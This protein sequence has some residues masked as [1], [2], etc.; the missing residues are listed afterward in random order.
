MPRLHKIVT[1][2]DDAG[3]GAARIVREYK[4]ED[5]REIDITADERQTLYGAANANG[6]A[7]IAASLFAKT[8]AE[9]ERDALQARLDALNER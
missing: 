4:I 5:G 7:E 1:I 6:A 3:N 8:Q 9:A 2:F